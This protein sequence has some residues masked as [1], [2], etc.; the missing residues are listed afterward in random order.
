MVVEVSIGEIIDKITILIIKLIKINNEQKRLSIKKELTTLLNTVDIT[1]I[2]GKNNI[3]ELLDI[4]NQL[5]NIE[6]K[7]RI[8]EAQNKFD[9]EFIKIAR[10]VYITND[11]RFKIKQNINSLNNSII[12]EVK[13]YE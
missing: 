7:I 13:S 10:S 2:D 5:W 12:C 8:K 6:D 3:V 1:K 4:N 9:D 11:I